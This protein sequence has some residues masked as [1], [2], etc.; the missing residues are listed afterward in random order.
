VRI[1]VPDDFVLVELALAQIIQDT[2]DTLTGAPR[3]ADLP[4][5]AGPGPPVRPGPRGHQLRPG[6]RRGADADPG[7]NPH[8][9]DRRGLGRGPDDEDPEPVRGAAPTRLLG[10]GWFD[11]VASRDWRPSGATVTAA[12]RRAGGA[13]R[14]PAS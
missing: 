4:R 13:D 12:V 3:P 2:P 9:E 6:H 1:L 7:P 5:G 10:L 11:A 8:L 14:T